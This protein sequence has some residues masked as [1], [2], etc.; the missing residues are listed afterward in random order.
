MP[1]EGA[2]SLGV[3]TATAKRM[4]F[5]SRMMAGRDVVIGVGT[6][7]SR[8]PAGWL[9]AGAVADAIDAAV[10]AQARR[11]GRASGPIAAAMVP[12]AAALALVGGVAALGTLR[13][14]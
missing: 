7:V 14:R 4:E 6:L 5:L 13:R 9:A 8:R 10:I 1:V 3:D 2:R 11:D 12:G